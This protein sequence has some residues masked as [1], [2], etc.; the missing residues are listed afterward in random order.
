MESAYVLKG[1]L[2]ESGVLQVAERLPLPAGEV[3][4][5]VRPVPPDSRSGHSVWDVVDS[6]PFHRSAEELLAHLRS[7]RDEWGP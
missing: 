4:V 3:E 1:R 7:L 5:I 2:D 6:S